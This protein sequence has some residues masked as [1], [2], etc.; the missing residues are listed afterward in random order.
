M[1]VIP[2][3]F[4][5]TIGIVAREAF[6]A[7]GKAKDDGL[8]VLPV[9]KKAAAA[10]SFP[11]GHPREGVLYIGHPAKPKVY[12][13]MAEFHRVTFEHK[14]CEA[15]EILMSLGATYIKVEHVRGWGQDFSSR[16]SVPLGDASA[17]AQVGT[18]S[19][20]TNKLLYEANLRGNEPVLPKGLVWHKHEPTWQSI[21]KGRLIYGLNDFS[22][23]VSYE[24]DF[25]VNAG[26]KL[27][28][29]KAGLD[30]GGN[31]E[32]HV[33]TTWRLEGKFRANADNY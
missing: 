13:T 3:P 29:S 8:K 23:S 30:I 20:A 2:V 22:M 21:S 33:S 14:F 26:L 25:G 17:E 4:T 12:Y 32:S 27:S 15:I 19:K 9:G 31:F 6:R 5:Q 16:L 7:W 28:L 11:P 18:N 24:D 10:I 1:D